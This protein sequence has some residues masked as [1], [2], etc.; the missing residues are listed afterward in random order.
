MAADREHVILANHMKNMFVYR[1]MDS[2]TSVY[3]I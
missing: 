3:D 2:A 1:N